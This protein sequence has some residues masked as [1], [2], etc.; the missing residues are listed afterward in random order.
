MPIPPELEYKLS[1][2][3]LTRLRELYALAEQ[4]TREWHSFRTKIHVEITKREGKQ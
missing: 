2:L 4:E 1:K 3:T